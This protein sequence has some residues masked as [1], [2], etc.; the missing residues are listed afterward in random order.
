MPALPDQ[1]GRMIYFALVTA[2]IWGLAAG[3]WLC[4]WAYKPFFRA[5][6]RLMRQVRE[7]EATIIFGKD[8]L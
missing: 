8:L 1:E 7:R 3:L 4:E 5:F 6:G 2:F